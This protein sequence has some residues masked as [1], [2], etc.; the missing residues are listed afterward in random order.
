MK[1]G[2]L[3][4]TKEIQKITKGKFENFTLQQT[5]KSRDG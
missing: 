5:G 1:R 4:D 2:I 3:Q